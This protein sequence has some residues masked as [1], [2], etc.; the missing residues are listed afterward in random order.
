MSSKQYKHDHG[1]KPPVWDEDNKRLTYHGKT[2]DC[3]YEYPGSD[4]GYDDCVTVWSRHAKDITDKRKIQRLDYAREDAVKEH[5]REERL[6]EKARKRMDRE[7]T[8]QREAEARQFSEEYE[9]QKR[10]QKRLYEAV[11]ATERGASDSESE[12]ADESAKQD[13]VTGRPFERIQRDK[14]GI[15]V[16]SVGDK[17]HLNVCVNN[18]RKYPGHTSLQLFVA[19]RRVRYTLT[20]DRMLA[21]AREVTRCFSGQDWKELLSKKAYVDSGPK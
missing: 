17:Y 4:L 16:Y 19:G 11:T 3:R 8:L 20:R 10:R 5:K 9:E 12:D 18:S 21:V 7:H 13:S 15:V 2:Y 14:H 1:S 6:I